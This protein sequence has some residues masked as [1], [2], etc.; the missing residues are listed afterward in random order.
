MEN[1][2][3]RIEGLEALTNLREL[4][5]YSN[6]IPRIEGL[7]NLTSLE[8]LWLADNYIGA[9]EGVTHLKKLREL[10]LARNDI[11]SIPEDV[12]MLSALT[13]LN[14]ADNKISGFQVGR[15]RAFVL[16][17]FLTTAAIGMLLG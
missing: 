2:I 6:K 12:A 10:H 1:Q 5:L 3:T 16:V 7:E 15:P 9:I 8:V 4:Y 13:S 14:L 11:D 17:T